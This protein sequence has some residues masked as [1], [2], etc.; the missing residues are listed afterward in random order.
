MSDPPEEKPQETSPEKPE[1]AAPAPAASARRRRW[2][3]SMHG[4]IYGP[5]DAVTLMQWSAEGRFGSHCWV[6]ETAS[7][8]WIAADSVPELRQILSHRPLPLASFRERALAQLVDYFIMA[9]P[10]ALAA[11]SAWK[12][13]GPPGGAAPPFAFMNVM[14]LGVP[15]TLL[16]AAS[17]DWILVASR[18]QTLGKILLGIVVVDRHGALP[19][20]GLAAGRTAAKFAFLGGMWFCPPVGC[21]GAIWAPIDALSMLSHP[22]GQTH[23]DRWTNTYV[24]RLRGGPLGLGRRS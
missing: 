5:A 11:L 6:R 19:N 3:V 1:Q 21:V 18:G 23:H 20:W 14:L 17:N 24:C 2:Y 4:E 15:M 8:A 16:V 10:L 22:Y 13:G 12:T 7:S 9:V